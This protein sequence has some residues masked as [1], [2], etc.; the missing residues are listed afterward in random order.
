MRRATLN[1]IVD[2]LGLIALIGLTVTGFVLEWTLPPCG[3]CTGQ[4]QTGQ[5][6]DHSQTLLGLG[7][8]DWGDVHFVLAGLFIILI[9]AHMMLHWKWIRDYVCSLTSPKSAHPQ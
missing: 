4:P 2:L 5:A 6:D 1:F 3:N 9:V 7:R 8:H